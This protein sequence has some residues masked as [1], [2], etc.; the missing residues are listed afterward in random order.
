MK[1]DILTIK[2]TVFP[3]DICVGLGIKREDFIA[4]MEKKYHDPFD[5]QDKE[6]FL[7]GTPRG[8]VNQLHNNAF[9]LWVSVF[10]RKPHEF[11]WLQH[12]IF[13]AAD[14]MLRYAGLSLGNESDEVWAYTIDYLTKT[15][16]ENYKLTA[17]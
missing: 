13:H 3:Y 12:E 15:I 17:L 1:K 5:A 14:L 16:Y 4:A 8:R 2:G 11:G 9:V 6:N 10:P 7:K